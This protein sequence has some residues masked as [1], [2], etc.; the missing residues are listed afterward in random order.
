MATSG[1]RLLLSTPLP[2]RACVLLG[3]TAHLRPVSRRE[4]VLSPGVLRSTTAH[5]VIGGQDAI[6][7]TQMALVIVRPIHFLPVI[8]A[9][10]ATRPSPFRAS[11]IATMLGGSLEDGTRSTPSL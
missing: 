1:K 5:S 11:A 6:S 9:R 8:C 3:H 4:Q 7:N 2:L 10:L